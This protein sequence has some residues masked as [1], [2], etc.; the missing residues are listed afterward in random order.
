M[1][2]IKKLAGHTIW[3]GLP[4]ITS[5]FLGFFTQIFF[6]SLLVPYDYGRMSLI[7]TIIPFLNIVF[8]YG[9]ETSY[10]RFAL[11]TDKERL[12]NTLSVSM[13]VS[14]TVLSLLIV[15]GAGPLAELLKMPNHPDFIYYTAGIIFFDT[16]ATLPFARLRQEGRPRKYAFIKLVNVV[17][18]LLFAIFFLMICPVLQR[19]APDMMGWYHASNGVAYILISNLLA[20]LLTLLLLYRELRSIRWVF[21]NALWKEVMRYSLPLLIVGFGGMINELMSRLSLTYLLPGTAEEQFTAQGIFA[22]NYKLSV[23]IVIFIQ[24]FRMAA[25]PFFFHQSKQEDARLVYARVMKFFVMACGLV[26]LG[27][28]LFLDVWKLLITI[29]NPTY[30]NALN[31]VP[32]ITMG[33]VFLGIYYNLSIWYKLTNQNMVGAYITL[34]GAVITILLNIWLIPIFSYTGA[35]WTTFTCYAFMMLS[36]YILGQ[37]Y[38]PVPYPVARILFYLALATVIYLV[39][40]YIR[41]LHPGIRIVHAFGVLGTGIYVGVIFIMEKSEFGRLLSRKAG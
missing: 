37:K 14:T 21:D 6:T 38:Y 7:Y 30:A 15:A 19:K 18:N 34:A 17:S 3:Y 1:G 8:T 28:A 25:E 31:I 4:T 32:I 16:L 41:S 12:Y 23:M 35:A 27:V 5:R 13:L 9:L 40:H 11:N 29:K 2:S 20:S 10:F 39:H 36:S 33:T 26:F 24:A 22:A